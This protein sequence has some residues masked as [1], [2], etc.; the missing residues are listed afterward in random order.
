[1]YCKTMNKSDK[2]WSIL[3]TN[4]R[5][6][7]SK[8][9]SLK[10]I[11]NRIKPNV[12]TINEVG[13]R[14]DKRVSLQGYNCYTRNRKTNENMGGVATAVIDDEKTTTLKMIEGDN[15]DEFIVTRHGQFQRAI[16]II[17][18]YGEQESRTDKIEIEEKWARLTKVLK[19][20]EDREE[21]AILIGD[22]NKMV[23]NGLSG[24]KDNNS[25][26]SFGGKL[27]L[28]LLSEGNY[29]LVNSS[30][31]CK[32]GPFT[33]EEPNNPYVKSCLDLT[34]V[35]KG[36]VEYIEELII[37]KERKF[38]PHRAGKVKLIY[39]DHYS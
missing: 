12:V 27:I 21:E 5:G 3:H 14:K 28:E 10:T 11:L 30:E 35:S 23:G 36:L 6:F 17:N 8:K 16:N 33:R 22:H 13:L 1:M 34:I 20:I 32:G 2:T 37:D 15:K 7:T 39:A 4:K 19:D 29:F 24:I 25:K 18:Y 31:K 38:T 9:K 26:V